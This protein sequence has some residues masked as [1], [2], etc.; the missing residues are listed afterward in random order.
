[1]R[2]PSDSSLSA[3]LFHVLTAT[4]LVVSLTFGGASRSDVITS[5]IVALLALP[6]AGLAI[7]RLHAA[8]GPA[9]EH[10]L[11][12]MVLA[13]ILILPLLQLIPLPPALWTALPGRALIVEGLRDAG[14]TPGWGPISLSPTRTWA[15]FLALLPAVAVFLAVL[16]ANSDARRRLVIALLAVG[17][18]SVLLGGAQLAG[19]QDSALRFYEI[20][21]RSAAVGFFSNRNHLASLL[22]CVVVLGA[23]WAVQAGLRRPPA[24]FQLAAAL[25]IVLIAILGAGSTGSRAGLVLLAP[26]GAGALLLA[27]RA[28]IGRGRG[29]LV[30]G[31]LGA[32]FAAALLI[33]H[34]SFGETIARLQGGF[35]EDVRIIA[36]E[37]GLRAAK[38]FAPFG[39]GFGSFVPAYKIFEGPESVINTYI[40]HAHNDWLEVL[41]EGGLPAVLVALAFI[42][43]FARTAFGLWRRGGPE[44]TMARAGSLVVLLLLAHSA[45]D[46]PLRTPAMMAVFA[47]ACA[48]MLP[49]LAQVRTRVT[50]APAA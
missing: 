22:I 7:W 35:G 32:G 1:M 15:A 12:L 20:T 33:V 39:S 28:G 10:R 19:G 6:I 23:A 37:V 40:N 43:W 41:I 27:W 48:L 46:Y 8:G 31:V 13:A 3:R 25:T 17:G 5:D 50:P 30:L 26:A 11:P 14:L 47:L 49:G 34:L 36:A 29:L 24:R 44:A 16:L 2:R 42:V 18:L 45:M 4:F 9:P 21:N 38:A